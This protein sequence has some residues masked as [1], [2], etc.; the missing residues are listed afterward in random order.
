[1][2]LSVIWCIAAPT[3]DSAREAIVSPLPPVHPEQQ[4]LAVQENK[5][6]RF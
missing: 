3:L 1:M 6:I 5:N 2:P 4:K